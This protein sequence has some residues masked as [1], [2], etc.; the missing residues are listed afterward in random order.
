M[1][2]EKKM[3]KLLLVMTLGFMFFFASF[4]LAHAQVF[5]LNNV[6]I[7][8]TLQV[9]ESSDKVF[10]VASPDGGEI[11][12]ELQGVRG[13]SL[14][15]RE[16]SLAAG[17]SKD[18]HI[19]FNAAGLQPQIYV[20]AL[21]L[22]SP[23]ETTLV[24]IIFEVESKEVLFDANADI[25]PSYKE[26][27]ADGAVI[28]QLKIFDLTSG[29]TSGG[30]RA[31]KVD[32][33]YYIYNLNGQ[34]VSSQSEDVVISR[35][36]QLTKTFSFPEDI[37]PGDYVLGVKVKY[38]SSI[39]LSTTLFT[40]TSTTK[41]S[42]FNGLSFD[43]SV[44][45]FVV[46]LLAFF[47]IVIF[48]FVYFVRDRDKLILELREYHD[49]EMRQLRSF[50][51]EQARVIKTRKAPAK[52]KAAE[53]R[54]QITTK[55]KDLEKRQRR[56]EHEMRELEQKGETDI[57]RSRLNEWKKKGYD[58]HLLEYK[59]K[60]LSTKEMSHLLGQWKKKYARGG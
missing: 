15:T 47:L 29:G 48:L 42:F 44:L 38:L 45:Y 53:V 11:K 59:L 5:E 23:K 30:L 60:G 12:L 40:I 32:I 1:N 7:K 17:E 56:R 50:L 2:L 35:Q 28:A 33:D 21:K 8:L 34:L 37:E 27:P 58:T 9:G 6:L 57:M 39:G 18:V 51:L 54:R 16:L 20:G 10:S 41:K 52:S 24:P 19:R 3:V 14:D 26:V 25:A 46:A 43:A 55:L 31:T 22:S 13:A 49:S 36:S 4:S